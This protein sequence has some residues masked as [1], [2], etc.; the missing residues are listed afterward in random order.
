[1]DVGT[2][3]SRESMPRE[4][5]HPDNG[6]GTEIVNM[7]TA[8]HG[9]DI[10]RVDRQTRFGNPF[11]LNK[12]GGDYTRA[13][14]IEEYRKWFKEQIRTNPEFRAAVEELRGETLGCWCKPKAC[15]A[16][17]I[18]DYLEGRMDI[19]DSAVPK[20]GGGTDAEDLSP[21]GGD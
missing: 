1:M 4:N 21:S 14:S 8:G 18:L 16:D 10:M 19:N 5:I 15:H 17:V 13:E 6:N 7:R 12:D 9:G 2:T 11:R 3:P 20:D